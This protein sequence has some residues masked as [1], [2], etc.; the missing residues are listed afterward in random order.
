M[1]K[2]QQKYLQRRHCLHELGSHKGLNHTM[3]GS[4]LVLHWV[5]GTTY[6]KFGPMGPKNLARFFY[7]KLV[8]YHEAI[9]WSFEAKIVF[10]AKQVGN[11]QTP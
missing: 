3:H 2:I 4:E 7:T 1:I 9:W 5:L 11:I 8:R 6:S 10:G